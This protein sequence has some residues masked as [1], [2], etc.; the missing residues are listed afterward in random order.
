MNY[1]MKNRLFRKLFDCSR[2]YSKIKSGLRFIHECNRDVYRA[3]KDGVRKRV[4]EIKYSF[5]APNIPGEV[6][7]SRW[8]RI[9]SYLKS[10]QG[11]FT[12]CN[13]AYDA[14]VLLNPFEIAYRF[15]PQDL[16]PDYLREAG[17][18]TVQFSPWFFPISHL[19]SPAKGGSRVTEKDYIAGC[20]WSWG[21]ENPTEVLLVNMFA[22][23]PVYLAWLWINLAP[24]VW[25]KIKGRLN[26]YGRERG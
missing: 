3:L 6:S 26:K 24:H 23:L 1:E 22:N 9:K 12:V 25:S 5:S 4:D 14:L 19:V 15:L 16:L 17:A 11:M 7:M 21:G 10:P 2:I 18:F 8:E 13:L 20:Y